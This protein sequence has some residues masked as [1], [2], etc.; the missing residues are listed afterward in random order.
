MGEVRACEITGAARTVEDRGV[1]VVITVTN[2]R[3]EQ[4]WIC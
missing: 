2:P 1:N 4:G 3:R